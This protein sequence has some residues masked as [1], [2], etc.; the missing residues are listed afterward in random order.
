[1]RRSA[2]LNLPLQLEFPA[3][4]FRKENSCAHVDFVAVTL[5]KQFFEI[6][7]MSLQS[8]DEAKIRK[9]L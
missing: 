4:A 5:F 8:L 1:M 2:V 6:S 9:F 3:T 7:N